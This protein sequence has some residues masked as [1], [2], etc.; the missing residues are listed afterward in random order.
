MRNS[1]DQLFNMLNGNADQG[2]VCIKFTHNIFI[3]ITRFLN[4]AVAEFKQQGIGVAEISGF[5]FNPV[6]CV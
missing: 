4:V 3:Q 2:S 5:H 1:G 6:S